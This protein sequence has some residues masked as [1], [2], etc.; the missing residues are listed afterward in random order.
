MKKMKKFRFV[1]SEPPFKYDPRSKGAMEKLEWANKTGLGDIVPS[2]VT[3]RLTSRKNK[4]I[5]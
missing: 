1:V 5:R 4:R 3:N 2:Q